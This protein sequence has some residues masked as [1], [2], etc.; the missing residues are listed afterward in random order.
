MA[1]TGAFVLL[2]SF[3]V[4]LIVHN[5][6]PKTDATFCGDFGF[7]N[8]IIWRDDDGSRVYALKKKNDNVKDYM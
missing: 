2:R 3:D 6:H 4:L 5:I 7:E 1:D 8:T